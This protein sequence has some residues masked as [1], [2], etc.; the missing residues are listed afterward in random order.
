MA[1]R[2]KMYLV[3]SLQKLVDEPLDQ[4]VQKRYE[5]FRRIGV[6]LEG[7]PTDGATV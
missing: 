5:K 1:A 6:Y 4:L 2:L 3:K 7:N